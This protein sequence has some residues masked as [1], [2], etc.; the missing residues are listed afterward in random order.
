MLTAIF[1]MLTVVN[2]VL[3]Y[4]RV[5]E[6]PLPVP[7]QGRFTAKLDGDLVVFMIGT[8][9][10]WAWKRKEEMKQELRENPA[11][12]CLG[13]EEYLGANTNGSTIMLVQYWKSLQVCRHKG[14][15]E[16]RNRRCFL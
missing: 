1:G 4:F 11:L 16:L 9:A 10:N 8:R 3:K 5:G 13:S 15:G 14:G 12:G 6:P 7:G 2:L